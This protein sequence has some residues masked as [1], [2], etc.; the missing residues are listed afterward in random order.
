MNESAQKSVNKQFL[1]I[2]TEWLDFKRNV[3]SWIRLWGTIFF[4]FSASSLRQKFFWKK[5]ILLILLGEKKTSDQTLN[6]L[7][8]QELMFSTSLLVWTKFEKKN[9]S[10]IIK[11]KCSVY[12]YLVVN[13]FTR[14]NRKNYIL[15][16]GKFNHILSEL[17]QPRKLND[18]EKLLIQSSDAIQH[19]VH[20]G[21][22]FQVL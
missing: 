19:W 4:L 14:A 10:E 13:Y 18:M 6:P 12:T 1:C 16:T 9:Y 5:S 11:K 22:C 2:M 3:N 21:F 15:S 8:V 17:Q 7:N 20:Q